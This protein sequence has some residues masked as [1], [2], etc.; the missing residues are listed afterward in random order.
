[1][2]AMDKLRDMF[3]N[4]KDEAVGAAKQQVGQATG[5]KDLRREGATQK[6]VSDV[7]QAAKKAKDAVT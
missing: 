5:D 7:K 4:K 2:G 6:G 3:G 1:M